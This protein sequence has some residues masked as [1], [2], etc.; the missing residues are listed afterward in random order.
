MVLCQECVR[1]F[2]ITRKVLSY[3]ETILSFWE[4]ELSFT[5]LVPRNDGGAMDYPHRP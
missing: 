5:L 2:T 3:E 4:N 1:L